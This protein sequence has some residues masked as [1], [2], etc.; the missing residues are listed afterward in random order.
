MSENDLFSEFVAGK[1]WKQ[2]IN[3]H[4]NDDEDDDDGN[5]EIFKV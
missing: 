2:L 1:C 4:V 5:I 3:I